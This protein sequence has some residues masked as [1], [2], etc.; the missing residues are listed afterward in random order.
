MTHFYKSDS[1]SLP[2][3]CW[4][5]TK[6]YCGADGV[7]EADPNNKGKILHNKFSCDICNDLLSAF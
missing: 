5:T 4:F 7:Q 1:H 3:A 6:R 2:T